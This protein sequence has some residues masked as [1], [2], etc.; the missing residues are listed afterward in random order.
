[1]DIRLRR[2]RQRVIETQDIQLHA[3]LINNGIRANLLDENNVKLAAFIGHNASKIVGHGFGW[4]KPNGIIINS[5][6]VENIEITD[7]LKNLHYWINAPDMAT[8]GFI[9]LIYA[10]VRAHLPQYRAVYFSG[11][12]SRLKTRLTIANTSINLSN[13]YACKV[14]LCTR[15]KEISGLFD[16]KKIYNYI[17]NEIYPYCLGEFLCA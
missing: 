15:L 14:Q 2:L 9:K 1:M 10:Y 5:R 8:A 4:C 11:L 6:L 16:D 7:V 13:R 12:A 3:Q 17:R